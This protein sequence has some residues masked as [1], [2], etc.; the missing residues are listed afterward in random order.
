MRWFALFVCL[1][2]VPS[3]QAFASENERGSAI[4][5]ARSATPAAIRECMGP[6]PPVER[7]FDLVEDCQATFRPLLHQPHAA[8]AMKICEQ[9]RG[10]AEVWCG[11]V[12]RGES[13]PE[14]TD[15]LRQRAL[16]IRVLLDLFK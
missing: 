5:S 7:P 1:A 15:R 9:Q 3:S 11:D 10:E 6:N 4:V 2:T 14:R 13:T 8:R 12:L 16:V